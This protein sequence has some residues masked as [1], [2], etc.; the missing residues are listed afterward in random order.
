M[1]KKKLVVRSNREKI[2]HLMTNFKSI[3]TYVEVDD[4]IKCVNDHYI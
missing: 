3:K 4:L 1:K 2:D